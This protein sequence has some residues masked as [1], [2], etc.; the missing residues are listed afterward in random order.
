MQNPPL[1]EKR[2]YELA[3]RFCFAALPSKVF[4]SGVINRQDA[5]LPLSSAERLAFPRTL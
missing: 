4:A 1:N 3:S 5:A 2:S